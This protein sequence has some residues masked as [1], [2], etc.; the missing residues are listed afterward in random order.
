MSA[1]R[2]FWYSSLK[3]IVDPEHSALVVWDCMNGLVKTIFNREEFLR[4]LKS[5]IGA[6]RKNG[7]PVV[8]TRIVPLPKGYESA[9]RTFNLMQRYGVDSPEKLPKLLEPG[10]PD[11]ELNAEI[12]PLGDEVV[13]PKSTTSI[14]IGT[15]FENLMRNRGITTILFTGIA[16]EI[17]VDS[18]ARDSSNRGFY[19]VVVQDC[20]SSHDQ[21]MHAAT[22]KALKSVSLVRPAK[23]I[24]AE[25]KLK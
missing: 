11:A 14:F 17:G 13:I 23:D 3:D 21:E 24:L 18:S 7:V 4:N 1:A 6:A 16:T 9:W 5:F 25:W 20:V 10:S 15:N 22:L 2:K 12:A 8:Y 19:T